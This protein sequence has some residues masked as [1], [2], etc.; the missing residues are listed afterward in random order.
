[1]IALEILV[2]IVLLALSAFFSGAEAAFFS[3]KKSSLARTKENERVVE[4][5]NQPRRL[6]ITIITGNTLV[7]T[8]MA[9]LAALVT[10][11][12][13]QRAGANV[14]VM[15]AIEAVVLAVVILLLS[16]IT[17]KILAIRNSAYYA[18]RISFPIKVVSHV[19]YPVASLLYN[20]THFLTGWLPASKEELFDSEAELRALADLGADRG[21]LNEE[22][23]QMIKSVFNYGETAVREIMVPRIDIVAVGDSTTI[24]KAIQIVR[25]SRFSKFPVYKKNIDTIEGILYAKDLLEYLD[26]KK[27]GLDILSLCREP[28]FGAES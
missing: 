20:L 18:R 11:H 8:F 7:N 12:A 26:G 14:S 2:V 23:R 6:L 1:M 25:E 21:S 17:P 3:L 15:V 19:L 13:A 27:N 10:V 4:L 24:Q 5:L 28:F 16:E 22:E 9:F